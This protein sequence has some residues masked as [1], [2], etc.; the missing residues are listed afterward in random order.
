MIVFISVS[1]ANSF[2]GNPISKAVA[3]KKIND[4]VISNYSDIDLVIE[5]PKYNFKFSEYYSNVYSEEDIDVHFLVK[6]SNRRIYD[7]YEIDVLSGW[8]TLRRMEAEYATLLTPLLKEEFVDSFNRVNVEYPKKINKA[9]ITK[10]LNTPL[11]VNDGEYKKLWLNLKHVDMTVESLS[12]NLKRLHN[13][14]IKKGYYIDEYVLWIDGE[15][16][17]DYINVTGIK[18]NM[19]CDGLTELI[20][21]SKD[22]REEAFQKYGI[23][24]HFK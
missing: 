12:T 6:Y 24:T 10:M 9:D 3:A 2:Y 8:N 16:Q 17:Y 7:D 22:N 1:I 11:N 14:L 5:E 23:N 18:A 4:Y 20:Q 21:Y 15:G 13:V 19:I